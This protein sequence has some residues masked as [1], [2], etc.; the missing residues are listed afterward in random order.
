MS[1]RLAVY[2]DVHGAFDLDE[3]RALDRLGYDGILF[4]GDLGTLAPGSGR[5]V[6]RAIASLRT[7]TLVLP[8]NHDGPSPL[9]VFRE[10]VLHGW[11]PP[12]SARRLLRRTDALARALHPVPLVGYSSHPVGEL[13]VVA[14]RPWAMDGRRSS[15]DGALQRLHGVSGLAASATRL[16]ALL[17]ACEGPV[18]VLAHNGP[19]GLGARP[20]DPWSLDGRDAGDPDLA[21]AIS[22]QPH[23][24]AVVAGHM[25]LGDT[26][27]AFRRHG[28]L[29]HVNAAE[30]PR[31][32][33]H[34]ELV[35]DHEGAQ[36]RW[37]GASGR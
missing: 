4:V 14:A 17:A 7:P 18:V 6:A 34:V 16:R 22:D 25:H 27:D 35:V 8:G 26:R 10:A 20:S 13:T 1:T 19:A 2:G 3:A 29:L 9:G 30:V 33:R 28:G 12:G 11:H 31:Q 23:V 21:A 36:G 37:V 5:R 15:F 32:G 24:R